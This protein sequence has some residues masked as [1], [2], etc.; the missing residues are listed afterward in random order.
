MPKNY[1][2][3]KEERINRS[4]T[5]Q[6]QDLDQQIEEAIEDLNKTHEKLAGAPLFYPAAD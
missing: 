4:T 6:I 2:L 3:P 5:K 1:W